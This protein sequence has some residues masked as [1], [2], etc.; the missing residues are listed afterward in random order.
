[1]PSGG[2][3]DHS[4]VHPTVYAANVSAVFSQFSGH[5]GDVAAVLTIVM[6]L[7][8]FYKLIRNWKGKKRG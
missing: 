5:L 4:T 8:A 2:D 3:V 6:N 1:M 7:I